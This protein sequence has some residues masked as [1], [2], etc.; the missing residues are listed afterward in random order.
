MA[1]FDTTRPVAA[2]SAGRVS[3]FIANSIGAFAAW[4]DARQT[5]NSLSKLSE[6]EL[7][8]IGLIASDIE[9]VSRRAYR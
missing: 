6:R 9:K 1:A 4:N 2:L 5:R 7:N 3:N 8:D